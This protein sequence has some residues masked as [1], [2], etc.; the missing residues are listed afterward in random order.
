MNLGDVR[1]ELHAWPL[2]TYLSQGFRVR[3]NSV[4]L[5]MDPA[6]AWTIWGK[7]ICRVFALR[8]GD[9]RFIELDFRWKRIFHK[10][11]CFTFTTPRAN[12]MK[13]LIPLNE[14]LRRR[15]IHVLVGPIEFSIMHFT[16]AQVDA[17]E[18]YFILLFG[19]IT[20]RI[21]HSL[22]HYVY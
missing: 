11:V 2:T 21:V 3:L 9:V 17:N 1:R 12:S 7:S 20:E 5:W 8:T 18:R 16:Y 13:L 6:V 4:H 14:N 22:G 19:N 10:I 15:R